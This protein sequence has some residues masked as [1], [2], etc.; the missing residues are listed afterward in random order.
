MCR[1]CLLIVLALFQLACS[2]P[3]RVAEVRSVTPPPVALP[4]SAKSLQ[5]LQAVSYILDKK[6]D[7]AFNGTESN[8]RS[9]D[10][11]AFQDLKHAVWQKATAFTLDSKPVEPMPTVVLVSY[12]VEGSTRPGATVT[13]KTGRFI[14]GVEATIDDYDK[15]EKITVKAVQDDGSEP[16]ITYP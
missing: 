4:A 5:V 3:G 11:V 7:A 9:F 13:A 14:A 8:K 15:A 6:V 16:D 1:F 2:D 12:S 10:T